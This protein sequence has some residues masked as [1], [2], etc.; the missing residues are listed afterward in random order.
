MPSWR[1]WA[2]S[3][4]CSAASLL[5][6]FNL[7]LERHASMTTACHPPPLTSSITA[8]QINWQLGSAVFGLLLR[9]Y[10]PHDTYTVSRHLCLSLVP[11]PAAW[12]TVL[13]SRDPW[14]CRLGMYSPGCLGV[15]GQL[16]GL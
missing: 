7:A 10:A 3:L 5:S 11:C 9:R 14:I 12:L 4:S 8:V 15:K 13:L 2:A 6:P 16:L 1:V